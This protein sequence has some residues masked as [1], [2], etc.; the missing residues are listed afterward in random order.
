MTSAQI[1]ETVRF[2]VDS[3]VPNMTGFDH[4]VYKFTDEMSSGLTVSEADLNMKITM[5]DTELTAG[6]DYTV[7]VENQKL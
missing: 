5:G 3:M 4:Y 6:N 7:T 2:T 1:G